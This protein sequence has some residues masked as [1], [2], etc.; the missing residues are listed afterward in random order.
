MNKAIK[1]GIDKGTL[2]VWI[3]NSCCFDHDDMIWDNMI[4]DSSKGSCFG[5]H[6]KEEDEIGIF[7]FGK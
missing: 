1:I 2:L 5:E 4:W 6:E 3:L 7:F